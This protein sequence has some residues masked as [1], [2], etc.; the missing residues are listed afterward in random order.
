[1]LGDASQKLSRSL[2]LTRHFISCQKERWHDVKV[3]SCCNSD[4]ICLVFPR[5]T[6]SSAP[7]LLDLGN[8]ARFAMHIP[9]SIVA[10]SSN[11]TKSS[12]SF[13]RR[14]VPA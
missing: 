11:A 9:F 5:E 12:G 7:G 6:K 1:M 14:R 4:D 13:C 8:G 2:M 10:V 3:V